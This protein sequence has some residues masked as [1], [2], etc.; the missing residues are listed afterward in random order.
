MAAH[1]A[2]DRPKGAKLLKQSAKARRT[3]WPETR[4]ATT[5]DDFNAGDLV[6]E[7]YTFIGQH[8]VASL[9]H[10]MPAMAGISGNGVELWRFMFGHYKEETEITETNAIT[11]LHDVPQCTDKIKLQQPIYEWISLVR[12][13]GHGL[14]GTNLRGM[15]MNIL[16][17][18]VSS[19]D[20]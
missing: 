4:I 8:L 12:C 7:L 13:A 2:S 16:P 17:Q 10:R 1:V 11:R 5:Y 3:I 19:K 15:R 9:Y 18:E 6:R 14:S 20:C